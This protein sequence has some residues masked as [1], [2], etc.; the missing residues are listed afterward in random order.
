MKREWQQD[1]RR[2]QQHLDDS[3]LWQFVVFLCRR[4]DEVNVLQVASS[5]TFTT[6]LAL[7]PLFTVA[8]VVMSAFPV[9]SDM[10]QQFNQ[11]ITDTLM[12]AGAEAVSEYIFQFRDQASKLTALGIIMMM[13]TSLMLI[14]TIERT[15]NQI[16]RVGR[17]RGVLMRFL[18]YWALLSLG[19]LVLGIGMSVWGVV[20]AKTAF[21]LN[22]PFIAEMIRLAAS[23]TA[24]TL[25][26]C[27]LYKIVP[28]RFVPLRHAFIGAAIAAAVLEVLRRGFAV[29]VAGFSSSQQLVYGAFAAMPFFLIWL[30]LMWTVILTAAV[31]TAALSYWEGDAFRRHRGD[32]NR[33]ADALQILRVLAKAQEQGRSLK[34]QQF[35]RHVNLGYDELG[36]LLEQLAAQGYITQSRKGGWLL[37]QNPEHIRIDKLFAHYVYRDGDETQQQGDNQMVRCVMQPAQQAAQITLKALLEREAQSAAV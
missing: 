24:S 16:W 23:W 6:L 15:F 4:F 19:P 9:F 27:L 1:W 21:Y 18:V 29:Y 8:L 2:L 30:N 3:R 35:R 17:A 10:A 25:A 37:K 20:W 12:P 31:L 36:G 11:L 28:A 26:L 22:Y 34:I 7:V 32:G 33:F 14:Q 13:V 5:L